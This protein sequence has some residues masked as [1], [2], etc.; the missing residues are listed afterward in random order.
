MNVSVKIPN[1]IEVFHEQ[2]DFGHH[3]AMVY[4]D[5]TGQLKKLS[6]MMNFEVVEVL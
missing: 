3:F 2:A 5:Y 1:A 6:E 4:G